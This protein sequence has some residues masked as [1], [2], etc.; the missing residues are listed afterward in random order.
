MASKAERAGENDRKD[1]ALKAAL[2]LERGIPAAIGAV[3]ATH[4]GSET[5]AQTIARV[6]GIR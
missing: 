4:Q 2:A 3:A 1:A 6:S 5:C